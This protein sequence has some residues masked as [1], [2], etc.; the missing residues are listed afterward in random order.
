MRF[1]HVM[2]HVLKKKQVKE[3]VQ[4]DIKLVLD[5]MVV[6][7][8]KEA[9]I[10]EQI[11]WNEEVVRAIRGKTAHY[12]Q[13]YIGPAKLFGKTYCLFK[14]S[15]VIKYKSWIRSVFLGINTCIAEIIFAYPTL[16]RKSCL[17]KMDRIPCGT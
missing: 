8:K 16:N 15:V 3:L 5:E 12:F 11:D 17:L 10:Q 13:D 7:V 1:A 14:V 2:E 6:D 4:K 9:G